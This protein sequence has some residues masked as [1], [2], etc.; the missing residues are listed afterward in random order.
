MAVEPARTL[1]FLCTPQY[2][3]RRYRRSAPPPDA[4]RAAD[5]L[6][7]REDLLIGQLRC[8]GKA[9]NLQRLEIR[10]ELARIRD[11]LKR[12]RFPSDPSLH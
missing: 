3:L 6:V 11:D 9:S 5:L 2:R 4:F 1:E 8:L 10:A 12:L 7:E